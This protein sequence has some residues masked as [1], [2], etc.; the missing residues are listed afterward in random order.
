[1]RHFEGK[2]TVLKRRVLPDYHP[3]AER[4]EVET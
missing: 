1:M 4:E 2:G 3:T